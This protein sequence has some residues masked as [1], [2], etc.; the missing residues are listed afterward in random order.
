MFV[1]FLLISYEKY[2]DMRHMQL[3]FIAPPWGGGGWW[4]IFGCGSRGD[5]QYT[6]IRGISVAHPGSIPPQGLYSLLYRSCAVTIA[7]LAGKGGSPLTVPRKSASLK[8]PSICW[9][10]PFRWAPKCP[11]PPPYPCFYILWRGWGFPGNYFFIQTSLPI[12]KALMFYSFDSHILFT[13]WSASHRA[14]SL[15]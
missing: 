3:F 7:L 8:A 6:D 1:N 12:W 15:R 5:W 2:I 4:L 11:K 9:L 13:S 10:L 14:I